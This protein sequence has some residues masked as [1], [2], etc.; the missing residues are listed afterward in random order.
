MRE[1]G[2]TRWKHPR[3]SWQV[4]ARSLVWAG[5]DLVDWVGGGFRF[6]PDGSV[7]TDIVNYAYVFDRAVGSPSGSFAVIYTE[8]G[9]KG[10]VLKAHPAAPQPGQH[11]ESTVLRQINRDFYCANAYDY[12]VALG[13]LPGGQEVLIH[14]PDSYTYLE[15]EEVESGRRLSARQPQQNDFFHS[16]LQVSA[17]GRYLLSAG[18]IWHPMDMLLVFD[19]EAA[20]RDPATLDGR[21]MMGARSY[22]AEVEFAAF[23]GAEHLLVMGSTEGEVFDEDPDALGPGEL[24]RWSFRDAGW[25]SRVRL[26]EPAGILMPMATHAVSFYEH[27]KLIEVATGQV[28]HRWTEFRTG[29][30]RRSFGFQTA[31]GDDATPALALDP[32]RRRFAVADATGVTAIQLG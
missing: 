26:P 18:W 19:L 27:P 24:G 15:I 7:S 2:R 6:H 1:L 25:E 28:V 12:P 22:V 16:R 29:R 30:H 23:D 32:V 4:P 31:A 11:V 13:R 8:R 5:D 14:C 20:L 21:G 17:D 3:Q 10:L 9:T